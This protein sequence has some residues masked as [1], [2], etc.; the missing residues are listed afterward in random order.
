MPLGHFVH[1]P[2][3]SVTEEGRGKMKMKA[4][5]SSIKTEMEGHLKIIILA[6]SSGRGALLHCRH[7]V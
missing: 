6:G 3:V 5:V 4:D 1:V 2:M 7:T